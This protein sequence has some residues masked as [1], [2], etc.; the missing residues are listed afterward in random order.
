[1]VAYHKRRICCLERGKPRSL[2]V[3]PMQCSCTLSWV[4][5]DLVWHIRRVELQLQ[6]YAVYSPTAPNKLRS[7][8]GGTFAP[9]HLATAPCCNLR[10]GL[11]ASLARPE[12]QLWMANYQSAYQMQSTLFE[13]C[14]SSA[15]ELWDLGARGAWFRQLS[16]PLDLSGEGLD[17]GSRVPHWVSGLARVVLSRG[18][19][20]LLMKRLPVTNYMHERSLYSHVST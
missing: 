2:Y 16:K 12:R 19:A 5:S 13:S 15:R 11:P 3:W 4:L 17:G 14:V 18:R 20:A 6:Q 9:V 8:I 1:M 10:R 7:W